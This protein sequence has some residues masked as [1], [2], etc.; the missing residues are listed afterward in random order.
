[1]RTAFRVSVCGTCLY[2]EGVGDSYELITKS[3]AKKQYL[4]M[5]WQLKELGVRPI[6]LTG[7][8]ESAARRVARAATTFFFG[9]SEIFGVW[10]EASFRAVSRPLATLEERGAR[11][12]PPG[13][14]T[15]KWVHSSSSSR[16]SWP[17]A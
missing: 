15:L 5:D 6:L 3:E 10:T 7:D 2:S 13:P 16:G 14:C 11:E 17:W 1:M 8:R 12:G 4:V 9:L